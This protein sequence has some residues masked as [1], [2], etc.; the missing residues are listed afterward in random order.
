MTLKQF[1]QIAGGALISLL[2]YASGLHPLIKWPFIIFFALFGVAL[3]FL[4]FEER[5]LEQ[6]IVAFF[7]AIYSPT[8]YKWQKTKTKT[9]FFRE[10]AVAP[11][12][13][14]IAPHGEAA[15]QEY[16]KKLPQ[17]NSDVLS[18][19]EVVEKSF[20]SRVA[21]IFKSSPAPVAQMAQAP[22]SEVVKKKKE[23]LNIPKSSPVPVTPQ[24]FK[25]RVL[26]EEKAPA[27]IPPKNTPPPTTEAAPVFTTKQNI[28]AEAAK[29]SIE[30]AP[31]FPPE[32]PN[33]V[34]G[35]V[36]DPSG[37][38]VENAIL[39]IK[40]VAGRPV[41]AVKTNKAGHFLVVTPLQD[42]RY[43]IIT[44]KEGLVFDPVAFEATGSIIPPIV[45]RAKAR[46]N[47]EQN[48]VN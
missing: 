44:E 47:S 41:R 27:T 36:M 2:F 12:E 21:N 32:K 19:L 26:V 22:A 29:F 25:P 23:E 18:K 20:L 30:A 5:P 10:E 35:Q 39:E 14:I 31:P 48:E 16:L 1:F 3:A 8:I 42:G 24:G 4:P 9:A 11:E 37:K 46:E 40:D 6:W 7:K 33:T 38:I 28:Q 45:I 34:T 17:T 15:L 13:K 43:E